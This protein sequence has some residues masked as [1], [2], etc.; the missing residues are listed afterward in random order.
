GNTIFKLLADLNNKGADDVKVATLLFKPD[1]LQK[2]VTPDYVGFEIPK[3]F[4]IGYGLD[5][6][7]LARN[8]RDIYILKEES[9]E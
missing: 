7:G 1:S 4:I 9:A 6:D 3:K 2:P 5:L 8:L